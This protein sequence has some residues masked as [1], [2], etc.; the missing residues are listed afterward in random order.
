MKTPQSFLITLFCGYYLITWA[1]N[2]I[3]LISVLLMR[4]GGQF[5]SFGEIMAQLNYILLNIQTETSILSWLIAAGLIAGVIGF[6]LYHKWGL[7]VYG[8]A[9]IALFILTIPAT[10]SAPT[11]LSYAALILYTLASLFIINIVFIVV[12][13]FN[14]KKMK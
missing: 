10:A 1:A 4:V 2:I 12:G 3:A 14:F 5:P 6:W 13:V 7:I 11:K 9:T 8:A